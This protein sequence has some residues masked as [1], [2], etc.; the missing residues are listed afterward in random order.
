M[1]ANK[2]INNIPFICYFPSSPVLGIYSLQLS[3]RSERAI[4]NDLFNEIIAER[5]LSVANN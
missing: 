3:Q 2:T 4:H 5:C 1:I